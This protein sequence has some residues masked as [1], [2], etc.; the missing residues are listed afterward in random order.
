M[1]LLLKIL[2]SSLTIVVCTW[3]GRKVPSLA[4]LMVV[5][6]VTGL[7]VLL[8]LG[9]QGQQSDLVQYS[10]AALWGVIPPTLFYITALLCFSRNLSPALTMFLS[11]VLWLAGALVHQMVIR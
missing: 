8:W 6:P 4:G 9:S 5:M 7:M 1:Q 3:L 2:L 11:S 10:R